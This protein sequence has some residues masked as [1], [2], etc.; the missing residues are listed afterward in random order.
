MY[1]IGHTADGLTWRTDITG[2][3]SYGVYPRVV[4]RSDLDSS[5]WARGEIKKP[6]FPARKREDFIVLIKAIARF[7]EITPLLKK[8][9]GR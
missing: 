7:L 9:R 8:I 5:I 2:V 1:P 3:I 6:G 4:I